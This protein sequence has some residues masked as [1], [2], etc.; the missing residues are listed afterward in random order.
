MAHVSLPHARPDWSEL[1]CPVRRYTIGAVLAMLCLALAGTGVAQ[2][3]PQSAAPDIAAADSP[4]RVVVRFLTEGDFPPFNYLDEEGVLGGFNVDLARAICAELEA[5]CDIKVRPWDELFLALKRGDADAV[6]AG[7]AVTAEALDQ[8]DFTDR[9]FFTPGRFAALAS[10]PQVAITPENLDGRSIAVARASP[11]EAFV[12]TYFR[13]SRIVVF[14]TAE[15]AREAVREGAA[16]YIFDDGVGLALWING[17]LSR[18]CCELRGGAFLEPHFFG[19]GMAIAVPRNDP[20]IRALL[21]RA[22]QRL[23]LSGR[24]EELVTRYFPHRAF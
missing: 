23:R 4:R 14:E 15:L 16:D 20:Q 10:A 24:F 22:L 19:D 9:Y 5:A 2:D 11:H 8:V 3:R 21:N 18:Q 13:D 6:I 1:G 17:T 7:H 12:R